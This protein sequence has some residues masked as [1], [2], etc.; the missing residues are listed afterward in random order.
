[1]S[2]TSR[3]KKHRLSLSG[4]IMRCTHLP[5]RACSA[6]PLGLKITQIEAILQPTANAVWL[7]W[8]FGRYG[9]AA[10]RF[11]VRVR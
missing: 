9:T 1:M 4:C 10:V 8:S 5:I 7:A 11:A 3:H 6:Q 2:F